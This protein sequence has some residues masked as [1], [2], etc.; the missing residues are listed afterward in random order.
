MPQRIQMVAPQQG[1]YTES[2]LLNAVHIAR[3]DL[4]D[5]A[6]ADKPRLREAYSSALKAFS[7]HIC[8]NL[9]R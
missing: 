3:E 6:P 9:S 4:E 2:A 1:N 5:A 8:A 7:T